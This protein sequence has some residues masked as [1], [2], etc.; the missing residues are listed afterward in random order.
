ML[1]SPRSIRMASPATS[2]IDSAIIASTGADGRVAQPSVAKVSVIECAAVK[3]V[4]VFTRVR[5]L[6]T[7]SMRDETKRR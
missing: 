5:P 1:V 4:I 6:R 2:T 3:A 7:I